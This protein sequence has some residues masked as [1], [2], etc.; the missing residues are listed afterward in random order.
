[1]NGDRRMDAAVGRIQPATYVLTDGGFVGDH[2]W[3]EQLLSQL[4][5]TVVQVQLTP[6]ESY[7]ILQ[8]NIQAAWYAA[9]TVAEVPSPLMTQTLTATDSVIYPL[10]NV[11]A[12]VIETP[13]VWHL[14]ATVVEDPSTSLTYNFTTEKECTLSYFA[15]SSLHC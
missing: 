5:L 6:C 7:I 15:I 13:T 9:G 14:A 10:F 4:V 3:S 11:S 8:F 1:M 2:V 12:T